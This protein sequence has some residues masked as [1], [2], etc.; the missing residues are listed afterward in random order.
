[1]FKIQN[2]SLLKEI[3][4]FTII[5]L[6][7]CVM[8]Y[9]SHQFYHNYCMPKNPI[10]IILIPFINE[11]P[12]CKILYWLFKNSYD[13]VSTVNKSIITW[14]SKIIIEKSIFKKKEIKNENKFN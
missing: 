12:H 13:T 8:Q 1:M 9:I 5:Y 3:V 2:I 10:E 6:S 11:M 4:S 7:W 14:T